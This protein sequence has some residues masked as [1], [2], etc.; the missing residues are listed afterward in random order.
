MP[1]LAVAGVVAASL[2]LGLATG[3][4]PAANAPTAAGSTGSNAAHVVDINV[5]N[6]AFSVHT[7]ARTGVVT[8]TLHQLFDATTLQKV[9]EQGGVSADVQLYRIEL[10]TSTHGTIGPHCVTPK[11]VQSIKAP[12]VISEY[13]YP[14]SEFGFDPARMPIGSVLGIGLYW[15]GAMNQ[16][17]L[18]L[19]VFSGD[20]GGC[21]VPNGFTAINKLPAK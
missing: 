6:A 7:N 9:L 4:G 3:S 18:S 15:A 12:G 2:G 20:P 19:S 1:A 13:A 11:G 17:V 5:D 10:A 14:T 16:P 21:V 8:V